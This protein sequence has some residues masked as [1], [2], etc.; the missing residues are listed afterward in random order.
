MQRRRSRTSRT[1]CAALLA[2]FLTACSAPPAE[3]EETGSGWGTWKLGAAVEVDNG[4]GLQVTAEA[5]DGTSSTSLL[6]Q[7]GTVAPPGRAWGRGALT[8]VGPVTDITVDGDLSGPLV[9]AFPAGDGSQSVQPDEIPLV[10]RHDP[11]VGWYPVA[12]GDPGG[13]ADAER[14]LFSPHQGGR[15]DPRAWFGE[16]VGGV[17]RGLGV[18]FDPPRCA[19]GAPPW[20]KLEAPALD[21]V[22]TCLAPNTDGG[23]ERAEV[24]LRNN[25]GVT[26]EIVVPT[27]V[28]YA[29]V[30]GQ[31]DVVRE[32]VRT[33]LGGGR[34]I[35][36]LA[37]GQ[38][39]TVGFDRPAD[40]GDVVA[41]IL[42]AVPA[43]AI[44]V[45]LITTLADLGQGSTSS[46]V[47]FVALA[48]CS[49]AL[50]WIGQVPDG[51][52]G[53]RRIAQTA[54]DCVMD[55]AG[56]PGKVGSLA[57][58]VVALEQGVQQVDVRSDW[59]RF[60]GRVE[61]IQ[62]RLKLLAK[63]S[64]IVEIPRLAVA[65][66]ELIGELLGQMT[67]G[68]ALTDTT[69][70]LS[71]PPAPKP[72]RQPVTLDYG[73]GIV[74]LEPPA[75]EDDAVRFLTD[76]LGP[77]DD[78]ATDA[79]C[80]M[81]APAGKRYTWGNLTVLVL[82][83]MTGY[84]AYAEEP[85]VVGWEYW[86]IKTGADRQGLRTTDGLGLGSSLDDVM[87]AVPDG[88]LGE[89]Y[90]GTYYRYSSGDLWNM[91]FTFDMETGSEVVAISSG[92]GCG[93]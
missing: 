35:V 20:A 81:G 80:E 68:T 57:E 89:D 7:E 67:S 86:E 29:W 41:H 84:P 79:M 31:S 36:M 1:A 46:L 10:L 73:G 16:V 6:L 11:E 26:Q 43:T 55:V 19:D 3:P 12:V 61:S 69:V 45:D 92:A 49:K 38:E 87:A 83:D 17:G 32:F 56:D 51:L 44:L 34:D 24:R 14:E 75:P 64:K 82:D 47:A 91:T 76:R 18:R 40:G 60:G 25:R 59:Q 50:E 5:A 74:G 88:E 2:V 27:G 85:S 23:R 13:V 66:Y 8:P 48:K 54:W 9:I 71:P 77:P 78:V 37:P 39:M 4:T 22:H 90:G 21:V 33:G 72:R 93:E 28:A 30:D 53:I 70:R 52:D 58:Q 42:S 15:F 63:M 62:G 65:Y